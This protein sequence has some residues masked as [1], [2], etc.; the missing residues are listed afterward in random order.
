MSVVKWSEK[1]EGPGYKIDAHVCD[2][3]YKEEDRSIFTWSGI[4]PFS[5]NNYFTWLKE[6]NYCTVPGD[7]YKESS[8]TFK[9]LST[10]VNS[11]HRPSMRI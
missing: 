6:E 5:K 7:K 11:A 10:I 2:G 8:I 1:V 9:D 4:D 3:I